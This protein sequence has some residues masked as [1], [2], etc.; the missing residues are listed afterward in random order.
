MGRDLALTQHDGYAAD[1][2]ILFDQSIDSPVVF[3]ESPLS[4]SSHC[5]PHRVAFV[6]DGSTALIVCLNPVEPLSAEPDDTNRE[7]DPH[8]SMLNDE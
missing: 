5:K 6:I 2:T 8:Q 1:F 3:P 4:R 7:S